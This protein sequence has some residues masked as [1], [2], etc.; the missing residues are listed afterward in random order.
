MLKHGHKRSELGKSVKESDSA[1]LKVSKAAA[2]RQMKPLQFYNFMLK[3]KV[4]R[5]SL[6][7]WEARRP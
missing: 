7:A 4:Y 6:T 5:S 3:T 1:L 2:K